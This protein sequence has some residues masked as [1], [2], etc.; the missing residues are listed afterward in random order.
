MSR[1]DFDPFAEPV[2]DV[3]AL[4]AEI[5][6]VGTDA[7]AAALA[8]KLAPYIEQ[9]VRKATPSAD[10]VVFRPHW[11]Q[12]LAPQR[13]YDFRCD[14]KGR[15]GRTWVRVA[16][17]PD[18]DAHVAMQEWDDVVEMAST[19]PSVRCRTGAGGGRHE[20]THQALLWLA[21]A[22]QLDEEEIQRRRG[23]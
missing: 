13:A 17:A 4:A 12:G 16:I 19:F 1:F 8:E 10:E 18:G 2:V 5:G 23:G 21:R 11:P 6:R 3:D 22:I 14:D 9:L 20:R 7:G 15:D